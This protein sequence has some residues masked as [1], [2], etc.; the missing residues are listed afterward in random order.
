MAP[1]EKDLSHHGYTV[2][3][4]DYP[5]NK[6]TMDELA[7]II[8]DKINRLDTEQCESVHFVGY[9]MGGLLTRKL[10]AEN[11][12]SNLGRVVLIAPPNHGSEVAN[13]L[14]NNFFYKKLYG[15]AGQELT[16]EY[17][18]NMQLP[19]VDYELGIIA[20]NFTID[21]V[22]SFMIIPGPDDGKV[23]VESTKLD[24]MKDHVVVKAS[25]TFFPRNKAAQEQV[26]AFLE[27]GEFIHPLDKISNKIVVPS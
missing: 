12:P 21:P 27:E 19:P 16:I 9:S 20:G 14:Q 7:P 23:S 3:N 6:Y 4:L 5:S 8:Q 26:R 15:P 24:G 11:Q 22:S 17:V 10:L 1:I 18:N 25:H 13:I 2:F